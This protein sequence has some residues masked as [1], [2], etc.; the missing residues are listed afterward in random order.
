MRIHS[1]ILT[2]RD[3]YRATSARGM[4]GVYAEVTSHGSR[5]RHHAF[6]L[7]LTG[8]SSRRPNSGNRGADSDDYAAT[9]DEWGMVLAE[10]YAIDPNMDATYYAS[11]DD[12]HWKTGGRFYSLTAVDQ[13]GRGGHRWEFDGVPREHECKC[14]AVRRF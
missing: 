5:K 4:T 10:L 12:F 9:W 7:M 3:I 2:A 11:A 14:G 13:H 8:T 6:N 1:D